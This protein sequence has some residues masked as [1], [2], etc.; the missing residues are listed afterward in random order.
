MQSNLQ[1]CFYPKD[2]YALFTDLIYDFDKPNHIKNVVDTVTNNESGSL[3]LVAQSIQ[4]Y[5]NLGLDSAEYSYLLDFIVS[6]IP[7]MAPFAYLPSSANS[8][9]K[10][11]IWH[12]MKGLSLGFTEEGVNH[13]CL[14]FFNSLPIISVNNNTVTVSPKSGYSPV[15]A[16][17]FVSL[18]RRI[19]DAGIL[20][21]CTPSSAPC[22]TVSA[23]YAGE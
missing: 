5:L 1:P 18:A 10:I 12:I 14:G 17:A 16:M 11:S 22:P 4:N 20:I 23:T 7:S 19:C 21:F 8:S 13:L 15:R 9:F 6:L 3:S 2:P